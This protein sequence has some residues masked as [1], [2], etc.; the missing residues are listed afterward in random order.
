MLHG[1]TP[2]ITWN[3]IIFHVKLHVLYMDHYMNCYII[4]YMGFYKALHVIYQVIT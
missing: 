2:N 3:Y 1:V 4:N